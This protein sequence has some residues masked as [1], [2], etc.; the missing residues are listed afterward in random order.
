MIRT[1]GTVRR[2]AFIT[3]IHFD[4]PLTAKLTDGDV[5]ITGPGGF[6]A[7]LSQDAARASLGSLQR[8]LDAADQTQEIYQKPLG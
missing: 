2:F 4:T 5:V 3:R 7:A 1:G 6:E 8:A